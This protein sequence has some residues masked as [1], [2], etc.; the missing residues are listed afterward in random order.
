MSGS[1]STRRIRGIV[2][3]ATCRSRSRTEADPC[4]LLPS[5]LP[6]PCIPQS[7]HPPIQGKLAVSEVFQHRIEQQDEHLTLAAEW[8]QMPLQP[9]SQSVAESPGTDQHRKD[10]HQDTVAER[11]Q[12]ERQQKLVADEGLP[13]Q[14]FHD[15]EKQYREVTGHLEHGTEV[16]E[17]P[18]RRQGKPADPPKLRA[19]QHAPVIPQRLPQA[20]VPAAPLFPQ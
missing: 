7:S 16:L 13:Q 12:E 20:A 10:V 3:S 14:P 18:E 5:G 1:S 4:E 8:E 9:V 6:P 19:A 11:G 15:E 17:Q 2:E